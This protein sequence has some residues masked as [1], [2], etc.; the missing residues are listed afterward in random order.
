[1]STLPLG[2]LALLI[3]KKDG[4]MRLCI[5]YRGINK[6]I[7]RTNIHFQGLVICLIN[8]AKLEHFPSLFLS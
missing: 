5:H 4:G 7:V 8:L 6:V 3:R 2:A 1:M